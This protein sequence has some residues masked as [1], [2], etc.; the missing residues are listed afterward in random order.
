MAG[1][2]ILDSHEVANS[3]NALVEKSLVYSLTIDNIV[4][5]RLLD[6]TRSYAAA[7]LVNS[8]CWALIAR[9]HAFH[10]SQALRVGRVDL[11]AF[12]GRDLS[13]SV[14]LLGDIRAA[15]E[16]SFSSVEYSQIGV[17]LAAVSTSTFSVVY[18]SINVVEE[19]TLQVWIGTVKNGG[20][21]V[22]FG[23]ISAQRLANDEESVDRLL[24]LLYHAKEM[25]PNL[26]RRISTASGHLCDLACYIRKNESG[27]INYGRWRREGRRIS[28]SA[29][30]GTVHRLIGRR[31]GKG[32][33][34][35]WTKRGAHLLLQVRCAVLCKRRYTLL[36]ERT[37]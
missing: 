27:V 1:D 9:Q 6:T 29:V 31:L 19:R 30:E 17:D 5:F 7:K 23:D 10:F 14:P 33:H 24:E 37:K 32:Q 13:A 18:F 25:L 11:A 12:G 34:M 22:D 26:D 21:G 2:P 15:L 4:H 8:D 36:R 16:W 3:L 35:C 20:V 28:T